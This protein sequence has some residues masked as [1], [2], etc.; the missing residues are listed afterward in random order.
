LLTAEF[1]AGVIGAPVG[2]KGNVRIIPY[3][4]SLE[5]IADLHVL[6]LNIKGTR[7]DYAV[8]K[9]NA[10]SR[11][12][13]FDGIDTPESAKLLNGA[14]I[15]VKRADEPPLAADEFFVEDL[16]GLA[17]NASDGANYGVITDVVEGGGGLLAEVEIG[18]AGKKVFAPF[19][20]EFFG[21]IDVEAGFAELLRPEILEQ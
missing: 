18:G 15:I 3:S 9:L 21:K 20:H 11:V 12:V 17:V 4:E 19:R 2:L 10:A 16:K 7:R 14:E 5:H 1:V 6:S 13:K 8:E